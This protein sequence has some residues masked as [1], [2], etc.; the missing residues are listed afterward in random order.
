M[1]QAQNRRALL[2]TPLATPAFAQ[3]DFPNRAMR[4]IVPGP[5]GGAGDVLARLVMERMSA[6]LGQPI[7][8]ENRP[9]AGTNIGMTVVARAAPDGYVLGL[10]SIAA[11]AVNRWLYRSLPFNPETDFAPIGMIALVPNL[12]VIAPA[13]PATNVQEFIAWGRRNRISFGSVGAGSSQHLAGAQFGLA[14]GLDM[15]HVAYTAAGAM[16]TDLIENRTQALFQSVSAV[17]ELARAGRVRAIAITG[18]ARAPAFPEVPT[19]REQG[20]DIVSTGWFGVCAPGATP[21]PILE[22]LNGVLNAVLAEPEVE[23][24]IIAGGAVPRR[25]TR[26]EMAAF[27]AAESERWRPVV[28]ATGATAD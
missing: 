18:E 11:N 13:I 7:A 6:R 12:M 9:G 1:L 10:A 14:T 15:T 26:A 20:V 24:R 25:T 8:I 16:N 22:R 19:M 28:A 21:E 2:A 5:A 23:A 3:G 17:A 27:M 4:F